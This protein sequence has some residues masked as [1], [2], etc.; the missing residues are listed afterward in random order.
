M[1]GNDKPSRE[2]NTPRE[3]LY[4]PALSQKHVLVALSLFVCNSWPRELFLS[5]IGCNDKRN[6]DTRFRTQKSAERVLLT[7]LCL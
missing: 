2:N 6:F 7:M 5:E 3:Q 4:M 1:E